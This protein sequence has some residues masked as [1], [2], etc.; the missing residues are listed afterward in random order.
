VKSGRNEVGNDTKVHGI[1]NM[2]AV[3]DASPQVTSERH[4]FSKVINTEQISLNYAA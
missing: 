2:D 3:E 1:N 4:F